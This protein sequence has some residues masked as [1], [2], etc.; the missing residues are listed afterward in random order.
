[1][2]VVFGV[3]YLVGM[4]NGGSGAVNALAENYNSDTRYFGEMHIE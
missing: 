1:M 2:S 4:V 3:A